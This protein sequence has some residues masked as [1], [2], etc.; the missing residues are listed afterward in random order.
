[1][2]GDVERAYKIYGMHPEYVRGKITRKMVGR[3]PVDLTLR[4]IE[5]ILKVYADVMHIDTKKFLISVANPLHLTLQSQLESEVRTPLG[6]ALQGQLAMLRS[7]GFIPSIVYTDPHSTFR[8][9]T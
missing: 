3:L 8:S 7:R 4:S 6:M 1:M 5:K 9:M 2:R